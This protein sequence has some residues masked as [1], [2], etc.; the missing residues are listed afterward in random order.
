MTTA[1]CVQ[2]GPGTLVTTYLLLKLD[3]IQKG[4]LLFTHI[5]I[6]LHLELDGPTYSF[7]YWLSAVLET[8]GLGRGGNN[9]DR[10]WPCDIYNLGGIKVRRQIPP[11]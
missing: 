8:L 9:A 1:L 7:Q 11:N 6:L 5:Y 3:S 2:T 4:V 10:C